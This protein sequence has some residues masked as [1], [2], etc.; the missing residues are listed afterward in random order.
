MVAGSTRSLPSGGTVADALYHPRTDRLYF[1]NIERNQLEVFSLTDSTFKSP[2]SWARVRGALRPGRAIT[3]ARWVTRCSSRTRAA[4]DVSYVNLNGGGSGREVFRYA[5][6]N[7]IAFTVT[8][9]RS[10][11]GF[12]VQERT[13][14]DFSDRPQFIGT[15]CTGTGFGCGDVVLT[16][17][18]TPTPGQR[19]PFDKNNGTL[20]WENLMT[21]ASR[22]SSSSRRWVRT[23]TASDTLEIMRYDANTGDETVLVP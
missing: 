4:T 3:T 8:S 17:S 13:Q 20:R 6:P 19:E 12:L 11:A 1:T 16:Y 10:P 7:I 15:T 14:Y 21:R 18:T 22:T 2:I 23:R 5:L 9:K